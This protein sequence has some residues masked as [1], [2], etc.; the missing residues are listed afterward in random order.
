MEH[1]HDHENE[2]SFFAE[3]NFRFEKRKFGIKTDDRRRHMYI[4]GKTG[5]GKTNLIENMVISDIKAGH[6]V[7]LVDPHGDSAEKVIDF[8]P[9][10]RINDVVYF[11]PA[12]D[13]Y[14]IG[15][16]IL[17]VIDPKHKHLVAAG[18]MG[19]FKKIWPDVWSPRMEYILNNAILALLDYPGSTLLSMNRLLADSEYRRRVISKIKDPV[20]KSFWT[21]EFER[22]QEKF[23]S[24]AI[25]P[26]QNKVGQFLS[27]SIIRNIVAQ[28][29][30]TI[31]IREIMDSGKILIVNLA[32]GRIGEDSAKL[33]GGMIITK[34]QLAAMERINIPETERRD[35]YLFV[36]EFQNFVTDS[37]ANI[38]SEAR[39][40]RLNL[41]IAHQY[42]EQVDEKITAAIFGN[43]GTLITFRIGAAD[44]EILEKEFTPVFIMDDI[45]NL[46]KYDIYLKLM[47]NGVASNPFSATVLPPIGDR[48]A[49]SDKVIKVSRERYAVKREI[50]EDKILRW[51]GME[52]G[53]PVA[54][55]PSEFRPE[56]RRAPAPKPFVRERSR[57]PLRPRDEVGGRSSFAKASAFA[58]ATAD[59]SEGRPS[60]QPARPSRHPAPSFSRTPAPSSSRGSGKPPPPIPRVLR[61]ET[62]KGELVTK[63]TEEEISLKELLGKE[64]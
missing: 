25:A 35:F 32:K 11:N 22:W 14:P 24:E 51:S 4:I 38:L 1:N 8:I 7:A 40:Y 20:V 41:I 27:V 61:E 60:F 36:D 49:S 53:E 26:I 5:M 9:A 42:I 6:G 46:T 33:L 10:E 3:T 47:I 58:K 39:K 30:S 57:E 12:D 34:L 28:V 2:I 29:K 21:D 16:N 64:E 17:E 19:V 63:K 37:F 45:V 44:A 48:K 18:M 56:F 54:S 55:A 43:V 23:R 15:F 50:V 13:D 52:E 59:K 62:K 31:N